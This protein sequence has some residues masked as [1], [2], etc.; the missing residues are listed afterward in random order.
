MIID[1]E[2][3]AFPAAPASNVPDQKEEVKVEEVPAQVARPTSFTLEGHP[4]YHE[5]KL[6]VADSEKPI[7]L[8]SLAVQDPP[9]A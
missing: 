6:K 1:Q 3:T 5:L 8:Y 7:V 4:S 9:S 2:V